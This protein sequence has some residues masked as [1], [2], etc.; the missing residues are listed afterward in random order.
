MNFPYNFLTIHIDRVHFTT[1]TFIRNHCG[2]T[3][4]MNGNV[5]STCADHQIFVCFEFRLTRKIGK[6]QFAHLHYVQWR[7]SF[8]RIE[9]I[10]KSKETE[11]ICNC[12]NYTK[13]SVKLQVEFKLKKAATTLHQPESY[14]V[15]LIHFHMKT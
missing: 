12:C 4:E 1:Y 13:N 3:C 14:T 2:R 11:T 10:G 9:I 6:Y 8:S 7:K 5:F 15:H